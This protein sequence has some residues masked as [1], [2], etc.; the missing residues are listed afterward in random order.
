[1]ATG[2]LDLVD[3]PFGLIF[4]F[5]SAGALGL[6]TIPVPFIDLSANLFVLGEGVGQIGF[7]FFS[8]LAVACLLFAVYTNRK[9]VSSMPT[10]EYWIVVATIGLVLAAP[11]NVI[12]STILPNTTAAFLAWGIQSSGYF[13]LSYSG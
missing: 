2:K 6:S 13:L 8:L 3:V 1:M 10:V 4:A 11:F 5:A 12:I 7:S 9:D